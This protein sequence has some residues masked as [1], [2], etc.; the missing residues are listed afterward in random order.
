MRLHASAGNA[1]FRVMQSPDPDGEPDAAPDTGARIGRAM[2]VGVWVLLLGL[3]TLFADRALDARR[4]PVAGVAADGAPTLELRADLLGH[5]SVTALVNGRPVDFLV[6]TGASGI[7]LPADVADGL[8]LARGRAFATRTANGTGRS[9]ATVLDTLEVGP[10]RRAD[11]P[12]SIVPGL[13][14][15]TGLLGTSFLRG[16]ELVQ[17]DGRL[18]MREPGTP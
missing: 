8:G 16:L 12:A 17:R 3:G 6:D 11:V 13:D 15:D 4:A 5:Y 14:G 9:Y 18:L 7:G 2:M 10:F 1:T